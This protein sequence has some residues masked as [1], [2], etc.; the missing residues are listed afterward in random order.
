MLKVENDDAVC[1]TNDF[2]LVCQ[3]LVSVPDMDVVQEMVKVHTFV[4][5]KVK[6]CEVKLT[7]LKQHISFNTPVRLCCGLSLLLC[8]F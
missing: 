3:A 2:P 8:Y 7:P 6:D 1:V 4:P 5:A